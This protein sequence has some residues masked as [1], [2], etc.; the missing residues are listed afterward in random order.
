MTV[1]TRKWRRGLARASRGLSELRPRGAA[2]RHRARSRD[3]P[4]RS[5]S[6]ELRYGVVEGG[7]GS[8]GSLRR[9]FTDACRGPRGVKPRGA[10][11][12]QQAQGRRRGTGSVAAAAAHLGSPGRPVPAALAVHRKQPAARDCV[13]LFAQAQQYS[14]S[15][16]AGPK[17]Q[18]RGLDRGC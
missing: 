4:S 9:L 12:R 13:R 11:G 7:C 3:G 6:L 2:R 16:G 17:E 8:T 1:A 18:L 5:P 14:S 10:R 15:S